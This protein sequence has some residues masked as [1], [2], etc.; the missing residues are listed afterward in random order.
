MENINCSAEDRI[1]KDIT[2]VIH[3]LIFPSY[4]A[5]TAKRQNSLGYLIRML[6]PQNSRF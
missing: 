2:S 3:S 5:K 4:A 1:L 6:R